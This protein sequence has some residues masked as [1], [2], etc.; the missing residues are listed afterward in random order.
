MSTEPDLKAE[1][2]RVM[3]APDYRPLDKVELSKALDWPSERR[4]ELRKVLQALEQAGEITRIRKDRYVLPQTADLLTGILQVHQNGNAHLL[5]EKRGQPDAFISTAN[6]GTA[7]HGDKVIAKLIHEG[8]SQRRE[9]SRIEA[10]VTKILER[11]NTTV[12][13]TLQSSKQFFYVIP[14]D[15][16][17]GKN[18]LVKPEAAQLPREPH[19][20]DKVVVRLE[21]WESEHVNPEGTIVEVLGPASAPGVDMLSI[22]RKYQLATSFPEAVTREAELIPDRIDPR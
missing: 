8:R 20:G 5:S 14:D 10:R 22:I 15:P 21:P 6:L 11:A 13:G 3:G 12:V 18:V 2:L 4:S 7:M 17:I 16:R 19:V 1:L 9:S